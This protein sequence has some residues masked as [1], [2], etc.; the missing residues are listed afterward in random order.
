[1]VIPIIDEIFISVRVI[2]RPTTESAKSEMISTARATRKLSYRKQ[3]DAPGCDDHFA[4]IMALMPLALGI[5]QGGAMQQPLT[6]AIVFGLV[7]QP[8]KQAG[9]RLENH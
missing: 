6:I 8:G 5:G 4:A 7:A 3:S 9:D 1:M 2:H